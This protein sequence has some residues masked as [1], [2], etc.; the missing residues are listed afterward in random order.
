MPASNKINDQILADV[1]LNQ[2]KLAASM[3]TNSILEASDDRLRRD[4]QSILNATLG[5]QKQIFNF[6]AQ[7]GWYQ[8]PAA[9]PQEINQAQRMMNQMQAQTP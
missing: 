9:S 1:M 6:M 2:H 7:K 4:Y 5:H 8:P 3:L